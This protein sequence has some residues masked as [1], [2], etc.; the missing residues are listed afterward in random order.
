MSSQQILSYDWLDS[1]WP[2]LI[3]SI[4]DRLES[5]GFEAYVV[6]GA[7]RDRLCGLTPSDFD[8]ATT[9]T[10]S[11]ALA[12]FPQAHP[13]GIAYGTVTIHDQSTTVQLTTCRHDG[14]YTDQRHPDSVDF[15]GSIDSDLARRDF[16]V[17]AMAYR[18]STNTLIDAYSGQSDLEHR[19][20]KAVGDPETRFREDSLRLCRL[21]RF[22]SQCNMTVDEPTLAAAIHV[23]P[24]VDL[25]AMERVYSECQRL[26]MS[27][28]PSQGWRLL[29][30]IGW[31]QRLIPDKPAYDW[32]TD[33]LDQLDPDCRWA[34]FFKDTDVMFHVEHWRFPKSEQA[35]ISRLLSHNLDPDYARFTPQQLALSSSELMDLGFHGKDLGTI[36]RELIT[37]IFTKGLSNTAAACREF[38][39][40][41]EA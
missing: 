28:R 6:G 15:S 40:Q 19:R 22:V 24:D 14:E 33:T 32:Q 39:D 26:M 38:I 30:Q 13:T 21:A 27:P 1:P 23:G 7:V 9:A 36:Q 31:I 41:R 16:T 18:V 37:A 12:L 34:F 35:W 5:N 11:E 3:Q 4:S 10:P 2:D 8:M 17:N 29:D 25:P 20:L